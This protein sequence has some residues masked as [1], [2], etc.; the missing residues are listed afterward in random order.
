MEN[1]TLASNPFVAPKKH[2]HTNQGTVGIEPSKPVAEA[3]G[4]L[5]I[6]KRFPRDEI[7][8]Y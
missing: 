2:D 6:A 8:A 7:T 5:V 4:K 3:Q 1:H